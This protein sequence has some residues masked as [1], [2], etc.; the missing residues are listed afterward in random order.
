MSNERPYVP[1]YKPYGM[2][3]EEY[4]YEVLLAKQE[5]A[6][7]EYQNK[8]EAMNREIKFRGKSLSHHQWVY[9]SFVQCNNQAFIV[10]GPSRFYPEQTT[11]SPLAFNDWH[12]VQPGTVG[13]YVGLKD[14]NS[15]DI[16]ENDKAMYGNTYGEIAFKNGGFFFKGT[17]LSINLSD[18]RE[19]EFKVIGNIHE[20]HQ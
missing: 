6:E 9:G 10:S 11:N 16:Y 1:F 18:P 13:E 12:E 2:S 20:P 15:Q 8:I 14:V 4:E 5:R 7:W 19:R 17:G 3:D